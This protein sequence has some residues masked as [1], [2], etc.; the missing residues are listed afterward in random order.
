MNGFKVLIEFFNF[1]GL[2]GGFGCEGGGDRGGN[3]AQVGECAGDLVEGDR[4]G[5]LLE[6]LEEAL[7][8]P[9]HPDLVGGGQGLFGGEFPG[10]Q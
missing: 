10:N 8:R 6:C 1:G 7:E 9:T 4:V 5:V 2:E 3:G